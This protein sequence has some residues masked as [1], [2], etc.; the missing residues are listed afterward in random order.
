MNSPMITPM[1]AI[2]IAIF[3]PLKI[4]GSATESAP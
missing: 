2:V 1:I 3:M 4:A